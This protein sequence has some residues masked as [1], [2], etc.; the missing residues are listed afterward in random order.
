MSG[1]L[2]LLAMGGVAWYAWLAAPSFTTKVW[3]IVFAL[4]LAPFSWPWLI[5]RGNRVRKAARE[6]KAAKLAAD[7]EAAN[8]ANVGWWVRYYQRARRDWDTE[9]MQL[10]L[11]TLSAMGEPVC[12]CLDCRGERR[13]DTVHSCNQPFRRTSQ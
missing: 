9:G 11:D 13:A 4:F 5:A 6:A 1:F 2:L 8:R 3:T 10:A 7:L 12:A